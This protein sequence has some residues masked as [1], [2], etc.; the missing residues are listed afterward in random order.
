MDNYMK[1]GSATVVSSEAYASNCDKD[2]CNAAVLKSD[3]LPG[4]RKLS[5]ARRR[6]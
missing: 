5:L 4:C 6:L 2:F 1:Y 3:T